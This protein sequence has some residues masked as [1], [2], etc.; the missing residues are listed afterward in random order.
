MGALFWLFNS[1][2]LRVYLPSDP[3]A[4]LLGTQRLFIITSLY[5]FMGF[6]DVL[7]GSMRGMGT[8]LAPMIVVLVGACGLRILWIYTAFAAHRTLEVLYMAYPASWVVT[9]LIE[10]V[11]YFLVYRKLVRQSRKTEDGTGSSQN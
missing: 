7:V 2:L 4:V 8:S 1:P 11:F 5:F 10:L 6:I 3:Q 9:F